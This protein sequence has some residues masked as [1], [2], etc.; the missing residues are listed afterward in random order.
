MAG[1]LKPP[2][3]DFPPW[4]APA[5]LS[6]LARDYRAELSNEGL[7]LVGELDPRL[8]DVRQCASE[9]PNA[10]FISLPECDHTAFAVRG[11]RVIPH[12]KAF[13]SKVHG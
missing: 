3:H 13:L 6:A 7:V 2:A 4:A 5:A 1:A 10:T 11:V 12:L 8:V 9:L